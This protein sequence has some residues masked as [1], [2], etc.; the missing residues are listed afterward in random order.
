ML[1]KQASLLWCSHHLEDSVDLPDPKE[2]L[3]CGLTEIPEFARRETFFMGRCF[4]QF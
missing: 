4:L 2:E 3:F 1:C